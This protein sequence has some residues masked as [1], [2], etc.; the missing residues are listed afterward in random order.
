M[1][2]ININL[3]ILE[4]T[5]YM[6]GSLI[7]F[8]L[9]SIKLKE[10]LR[11]PKIYLR[12]FFFFDKKEKNEYGQDL[13]P[14]EYECELL[15]TGKDLVGE[16]IFKI[17]QYET[18]QLSGIINLRKNKP[19]KIKGIEKITPSGINIK[20]I[21]TPFKIKVFF[22]DIKD[23]KYALHE[24]TLGEGGAGWSVTKNSL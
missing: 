11:R 3:S 14:L 10:I 22:K 9:G 20:E 19:V 17:G 12:P 18:H 2:E 15:N 13:I 24:L 21:K 6:F 1:V 5:F 8:I 23:K 4:K 7:A 16:L